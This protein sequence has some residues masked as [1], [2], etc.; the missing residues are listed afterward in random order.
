MINQWI[1]NIVGVIVLGTLM[2]MIIPKGNLKT[3]TRFFVGLVTMLVILQPLLKLIGHYPDFRSNL[4]F[5]TMEAELET[6]TTRNQALEINQ[7]NL[8]MQLYKD[9]LEEDVIRRVKKYLSDATNV[10]ATITISEPDDENIYSINRIDV[11]IGGHNPLEINPVEISI[12]SKSTR[13]E[14]TTTNQSEYEK[15]DYQ[16]IKEDLSDAYEIDDSRIY[17]SNE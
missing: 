1:A 3:Y 8:L 9:K 17:I 6:I 2:D 16:M 12:G 7:E 15:K 14:K 13:Y 5:K 11:T 10:S 4:W